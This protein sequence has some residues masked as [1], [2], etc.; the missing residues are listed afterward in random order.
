MALNVSKVVPRSP[1]L[2]KRANVSRSKRVLLT[3]PSIKGGSSAEEL[4][5]LFCINPVT[6][7]TSRRSSSTVC[8]LGKPQDTET[9]P[10]KDC[11]D[12]PK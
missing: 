10:H 7:V 5:G 9:K 12:I 2:A 8:F 4:Q 6:S 11:L 1:K 3:F